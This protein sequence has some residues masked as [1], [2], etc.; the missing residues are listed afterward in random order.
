MPAGRARLEEL[1]LQA[2]RSWPIQ[3]RR[4][5][6][7]EILSNPRQEHQLLPEECYSSLFLRHQQPDQVPLARRRTLRP[8]SSL[9]LDKVQVGS[10]AERLQRAIEIDDWTAR[11]LTYDY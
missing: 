4:K 11:V 6:R 10:L 9:Q 2:R 8:E 5:R 3:R 1:C 7:Y